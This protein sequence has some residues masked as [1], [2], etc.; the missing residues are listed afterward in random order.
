M[1]DSFTQVPPD[2]TGDK[3]DTEQLTVNAQTV[4]RQRIQLAGTSDTAIAPVSLANG[5][6]VDLGTN[7]DVATAGD[8]AHD[9]A[10]SG[11]P[12]KVGGK[13][14]TT[15]PTAAATLDR[16]DQTMTTQGGALIAGTDGTTP[17]NIEVNASG[18][19]EVDIVAQQL[20]SLVVDLGADNDVVAAGDV[21]HDAA[22]SGNPVKIGGKA[23]TTL[24]TA[25]ANNDRVD[26]SMASQGGAVVAGDDAGTP[27]EIAVN[28]SGQLEVDLAAAQHGD[29]NVSLD[30]EAVVLGAGTAEV[31]K[32]AAGVA[33]VGSVVQ[34]GT[35][36][37]DNLSGAAQV[38]V[39][40]ASVDVASSGDNSI[41]A[42][43]AGKEIRVISY[44]LVASGGA[45]TLFWNSSVGG[46]LSG[47][48]GLADT[49]GISAQ[50]QTGLFETVAGEAL[51]LNLSAATSVD[52]HI[53]YIEVD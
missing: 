35:H 17:V 53:S 50:S 25:A 52:G 6:L 44:V 5:L 7:N 51:E 9:A 13:A 28:A 10:D 31:G 1:A 46:A 49:G 11:N 38:E 39:K 47:G 40:F 32:L 42:L 12:V 29:L 3:I 21:A 24:P 26:L 4:E 43:V 2:S 45:N 41:V 14:Y 23:F 18:Q 8:I 37:H 16:V 19:L 36:L 34:S 20:S 15:L 22:D 33:S 30:S 27:R 48:M